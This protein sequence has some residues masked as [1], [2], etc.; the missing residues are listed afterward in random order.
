MVQPPSRQCRNTIFHLLAVALRPTEEAHDRP[1]TPCRRR[2]TG[3]GSRLL[4]DSQLLV[5]LGVNQ[6]LHVPLKNK[7][8]VLDLTDR[9]CWLLRFNVVYWLFAFGTCVA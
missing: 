5:N 1:P 7:R 8:T 4:V 3:L 6:L 9:Y 2:W